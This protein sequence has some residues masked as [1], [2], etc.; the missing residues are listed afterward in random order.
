MICTV[1]TNSPTPIITTSRPSC[2]HCQTAARP[3]LF[4]RQGRY[5]LEDSAW[6]SAYMWSF[7]RLLSPFCTPQGL[8]GSTGHQLSTLH[9]DMQSV[10]IFTPQSFSSKI[11]FL[12]IVFLVLDCYDRDFL[13]VREAVLF[14]E[15][16]GRKKP[17]YCPNWV[18]PSLTSHVSPN[19]Y[20]LFFYKL[21]D[22]VDGGS[23][24]NGAS[25]FSFYSPWSWATCPKLNIL[26]KLCHY[27]G[28]Q[29]LRKRVFQDA[30]HRQTQGHRYSMNESAHWAHSVKRL[31]TWKKLWTLKRLWKNQKF[32]DTDVV[33]KKRKLRWIRQCDK[34]A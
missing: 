24:I 17:R 19:I 26:L 12:V 9:S 27:R 11:N 16:E 21:R 7:S 30:T 10:K 34:T 25:Q 29:D 13:C 18:N 6:C 8:Q 31:E 33:E 14:E 32:W 4:G 15:E 3:G 28:L 5:I 20:I 23:G 1:T 2:S 22:L